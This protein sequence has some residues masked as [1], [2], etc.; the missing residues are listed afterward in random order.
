MKELEIS[1]IQQVDASDHEPQ[2]IELGYLRFGRFP[3]GVL[4]ARAVGALIREPEFRR[5]ALRVCGVVVHGCAFG[6]CGERDYERRSP[7]AARTA[8]ESIWTAGSPLRAWA[9][10]CSTRPPTRS[11]TFMNWVDLFRKALAPSRQ[12]SFLSQAAAGLLLEESQKE[13]QNLSPA[14][15]R[16]IRTSWCVVRFTSLA[17][18]SRRSQTK[19]DRISVF[20]FRIARTGN[21][22][23]GEFTFPVSRPTQR[24]A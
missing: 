15:V 20:G 9:C 7:S 3:F 12:A 16:I 8:G 6:S 13:R 5:R 24:D 19:A 1:I 11:A 10:T 2:A 21:G 23:R 22:K 18:M 17:A 4:P 14:R